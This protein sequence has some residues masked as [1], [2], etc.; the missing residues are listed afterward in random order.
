LPSLKIPDMN[1]SGEQ[2]T[3]GCEK[4]VAFVRRSILLLGLTV[5]MVTLAASPTLALMLRNV[6]PEAC[7]NVHQSG[8]SAATF[9]AKTERGHYLCCDRRAFFL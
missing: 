4:G 3:E 5:L 7:D 1:Y 6:S 8:K 9:K 2:S